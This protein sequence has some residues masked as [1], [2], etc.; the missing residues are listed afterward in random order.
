VLNDF[1]MG[2]PDGPGDDGVKK[3]TFV[4]FVWFVDK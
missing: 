2:R 1:G 3:V 4:W